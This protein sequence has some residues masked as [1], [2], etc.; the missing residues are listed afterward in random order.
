MLIAPD[1]EQ[2]VMLVPAIAVG[3][4]PIV[5]VLVEVTFAQGALPVAVS[6]RVLLPASISAAL[7]KYVQSVRELGLL[8]AP[9]P[10]EVHVIPALLDADEP[11]VIFTADELAQVEIAVPAT[12]VAA[13]FTVILAV[14]LLLTALAQ[15]DPKTRLV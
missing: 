13:L 10:L 14:L 5:I 2:V 1:L 12:A 3:S 4:V 6:V 15:P 9:V 7:G 8:K 11:A